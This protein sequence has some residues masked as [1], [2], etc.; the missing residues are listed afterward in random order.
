MAS[1]EKKI[2]AD[3]LKSV[4][5][6]I[7][8]SAGSSP[9]ECDLL[10]DHLIE[11]NLKG[12]DSHGIG[13]IPAYIAAL[14][15]NEL[16]L[17]AAPR[18][19]SEFG[20]TLVL[21]GGLGLGQSIAHDAMAM[22]I[23]RAKAQ[24]SSIV[25]LHNSHHIGRIGHWAEQCAAAGLVSIHFVNVISEP[26][27]APFG[28]TVARVVTNPIS[29]GIPR[30]G[31]AAVIV[32]FATSRLAHGKIR[33][34]YNKGVTVPDG[35]LID[36]TGHPTNDPA[37]LFTDPRG[38]I[39]PFGEHKGWTLAFACE[40]LAGALTGGEAIKGFVTQKAIVNNMLSILI[41]PNRIGTAPS[42]FRELEEMIA[43]VQSPAPGADP[44]VLLPGDPER[45]TRAERLRDGIPVDPA[46]WAQIVAAA[47]EIGV[48]DSTLEEAAA[49]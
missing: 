2:Y 34:A 12:H 31:H 32:D 3:N 39:L 10:A 44:S 24:G 17:N 22:G 23:E 47:G 4:A 27:V 30:E 14:K 25:A 33:V 37:T 8:F 43:W 49:A 29:I 20:S 1:G 6:H 40:A 18:V 46:T 36:A 7:F 13:M 42:Y 5:R 26:V 19:V 35:T 48:S 45:K 21:D 15:A 16:K 11:A 9:R 41:A 38:A 28:G